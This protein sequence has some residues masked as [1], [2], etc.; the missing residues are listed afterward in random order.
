MLLSSDQELFPRKINITRFA[1]ETMSYLFMLP[2]R[3]TEHVKEVFHKTRDM[4]ANTGTL[5]SEVKCMLFRQ[6]KEETEHAHTSSNVL[7]R[8]LQH[9]I[10]LFL[11][12]MF[13]FGSSNRAKGR[14][15]THQF[16]CF[17][18]WE[19]TL[20]DNIPGCFANE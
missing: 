15:D 3:V 5:V 8:T 12:S 10:L 20:Y 18:S 4:T 17:Q 1:G 13:S 6:D 9:N 2:S 14:Y 7:Q 11:G 16:W 19:A